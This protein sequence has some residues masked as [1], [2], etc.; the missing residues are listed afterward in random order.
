MEVVGRDDKLLED[1]FMFQ[2]DRAPSHYSQFGEFLK[3]RFLA[4]WIVRR[5]AIL[6]PQECQRIT[7]EVLRN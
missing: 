3:E 5:G 1:Q 7:P 2:H 6:G 4:H